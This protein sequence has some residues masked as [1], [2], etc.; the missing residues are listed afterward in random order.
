MRFHSRAWC[1]ATLRTKEFWVQ[2]GL[3]IK[4]AQVMGHRYPDRNLNRFEGI[5][6]QQAQPLVEL[7]QRYHQLQRRAIHKRIF[8]ARLTRWPRS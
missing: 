6:S 5:Q 7:R 3:R 1:A 8:P 2:M 4:A